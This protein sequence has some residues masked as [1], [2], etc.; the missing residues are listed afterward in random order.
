VP[1]IDTSRLKQ[2]GTMKIFQKNR[3]LK[4]AVDAMHTNPD[5]KKPPTESGGGFFEAQAKGTNQLP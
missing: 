5:I 3:R 1:A 4:T 2:N